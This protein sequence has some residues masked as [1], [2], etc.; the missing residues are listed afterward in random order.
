MTLRLAAVWL[1]AIV[2]S[3]LAA[4]SQP[5]PVG[6][7]NAAALPDASPASQ[8]APPAASE[9]ETRPLG[10]PNSPLSARPVAAAATG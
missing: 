6:V 9:L 3:P 4:W 5:P 1:V 7:N 2:S 10:R 8:A